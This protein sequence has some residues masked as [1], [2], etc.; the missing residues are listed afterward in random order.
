MAASASTSANHVPVLGTLV[1]NAIAVGPASARLSMTHSAL[2]ASVCFDREILEEQSVHRTLQTD[3][4]LVDLAFG[5]SKE[6][7]SKKG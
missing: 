4:E 5:A 6:H 7:N 1:R 2:D 3:V